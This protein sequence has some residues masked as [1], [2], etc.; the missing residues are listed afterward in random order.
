M[1]IE[2]VFSIEGR[3]TVVTGRIERGIAKVNEEMEIIGLKPTQ[4][5]VITGIEMF[6]KLLDEG[7]AGDNVGALLRGLKKKTLNAVRLSPNRA[8]LRLI[9]NLTRKSTCFPKRKAA[10]TLLF[11]RV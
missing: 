2:D 11:Q 9:P 6:N 10:A 7:R 1:P 3:G 8:A 5:T 4:K